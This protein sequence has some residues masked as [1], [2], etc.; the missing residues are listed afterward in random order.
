MRKLRTLVAL[1]MIGA[2]SFTAVSTGTSCNRYMAGFMVQAIVATA[3]VA[4][5]LAAHDAHFHSHHC[6]HSY[7]IVEERPVYHYEERWEYY[8]EESGRWYYYPDGLPESYRAPE[9]QEEHPHPHPHERQ[10]RRQQQYD[11]W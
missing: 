5:V 7:V 4:T 8:D 10:Q 2:F 1:M 9:R 3:V 11:E 6:G